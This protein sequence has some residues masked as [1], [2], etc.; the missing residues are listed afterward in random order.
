[1]A[2]ADS[3]GSLPPSEPLVTVVVTNHD[4]GRFLGRGLDS[5]L[6]QTYEHVEIVVVDDGSTDDSPAVIDRY[7]GRIVGLLCDH[8]GQPASFNRGFA[9]SHGDVVCFMDSD[10]WFLPNKIETVV[11]VLR[12]HPE[13][14]GCFHARTLETPQGSEPVPLGLEGVVDARHELAQ[15][16]PPFIGTVTSGIVLRRTALDRMLPFPET[17]GTGVQDH[18]LKWGGLAL[19]P[20]YFLDDALTVQVMHGANASDRAELHRVDNYLQNALYFDDRFPELHRLSERLFTQAAALMILHPS[21][22]RSNAATA[23]AFL[24]RRPLR[25]RAR[26]LC[27]SCLSALRRVS[28]GLTRRRR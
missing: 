28:G 15:G 17:E 12:E 22:R 21:Q 13:V 9:A 24:R 10:D 14:V 2:P 7:R 3:T 16:R 5:L 26:L 27:A 19:G 1:V 6:A 23:R 4:Y 18:A 11:R 25:T 20:V 8:S